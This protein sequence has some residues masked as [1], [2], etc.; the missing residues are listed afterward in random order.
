MVKEFKFEIYQRVWIPEL[1]TY[2]TIISIFI[3]PLGIEYNVRFF[4]NSD[5][6]KIYF[7]EHELKA[8]K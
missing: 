2:G 5:E 7:L 8:F 6:K 4:H 1:E 3:T